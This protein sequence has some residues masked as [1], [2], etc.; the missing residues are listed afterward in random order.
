MK[1]FTELLLALPV[2]CLPQRDSD[3]FTRVHALVSC[4]ELFASLFCDT[5]VRH[6]D[7]QS[8]EFS[9]SGLEKCLEK[10]VGKR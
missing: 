1:G 7:W 4:L 5:F 8:T 10:W 3:G 2:R 6:D 9:D